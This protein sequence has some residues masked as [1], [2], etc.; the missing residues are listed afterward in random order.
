MIEL[1]EPYRPRRVR[2]LDLW[3][4]AGWRIKVY[5]ITYE[6]ER[7]AEELVEAARVQARHVLPEPAVTEDRHGVGFLGVHEG[8]GSNLVFL[9]W[10]VNQNEVVHHAWTSE[11][12][13]PDEL[14]PTESGEP[15][16]CAWDLRVIA[17]ER[18]AWVEHVLAGGDGPDLDRYLTD[19]LD[20]WY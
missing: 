16:A 9:D 10:W 1:E 11:V 19:T 2:P 18:T 7:V 15:I 8:R 6:G 17:H 3:D 12:L 4:P 14:V 13:E 5:T 20:G